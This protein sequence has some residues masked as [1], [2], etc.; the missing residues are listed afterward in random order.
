V[1]YE[2]FTEIVPYDHL[3]ADKM[4]K[5]QQIIMA[6][7]NENARPS[8]PP[9]TIQS[10]PY[11]ADLMLAGWDQDATQ[12]PTF[13]QIMRILHR[14]NPKQESIIDSMLQAVE[15]HA[16]KLE[17]LTKNMENLLHNLLPPSIADKLSRGEQVEPEYYASSTLFFSDIVGFTSIAAAST[18]IDIVNL[19]N[20]L[21]SGQFSS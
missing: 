10:Y 18:P 16:L 4:L 17:K 13:S 14:A 11:M 1:V 6:V 9:Q 2:A 5:P 7:K 20:D 19:L 3:A 8:I 12:R 21:Y 15:N